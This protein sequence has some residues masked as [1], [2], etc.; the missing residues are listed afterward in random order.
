[1]AISNEDKQHSILA[2]FTRIAGRYDLLNRLMTG[3][4]DIRLRKETV[5]KLEIHEHGRYLDIG[6]GT[7]DLALEISRRSPTSRVFACDLTWA[8][9]HIAANR[10]GSKSIRW[11]I[12]DAQHLPFSA[13]AFDGCCSGYLLRNVSDVSLTLTE[14]YRVLAGGGRVASLDTTP[15]SSGL[16]YPFI[17][18]HLRC[19]IPLLGWLV[20][21]DAEAYRYLPTSTMMFLKAEN[22][23]VCFLKTGFS[24]IGFTRRLFGTMAVHWGSKAEAN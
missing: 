14:Q 16:L 24:K 5:Q 17:Q 10:P 11:V 19:I 21:G 9:L 15:P 8:M 1:M 22:L 13:G 12:A 3:G 23:A 7:G 4:Q 2:L 18:F 20:A 6:T